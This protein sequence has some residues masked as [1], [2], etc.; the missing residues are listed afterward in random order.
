M[1]DFEMMAGGGG[2]DGQVAGVGADDQVAAAQS[3]L[4]D[5]SVDNVSGSGAAAR[6]PAARARMSSRVL[7]SASGQ[8]PDRRAWRLP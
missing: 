3:A 7:V 2:D 4:D 8:E 6:A 1:V 5:A